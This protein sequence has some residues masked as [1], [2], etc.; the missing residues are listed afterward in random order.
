MSTKIHATV[1][2]KATNVGIRDVTYVV[3]GLLYH[4]SYLRIEG[5]YTDTAGFTDHVFALMHLLGFRFAPRLRDLGKPDFTCE[6]T[7]RHT[8]PSSP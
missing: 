4:E 1:N 3:D 6:D 5:H 8:F 7:P 2:A